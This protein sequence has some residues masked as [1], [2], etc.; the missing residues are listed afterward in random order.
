MKVLFAKVTLTR[1]NGSLHI[2]IVTSLWNMVNVIYVTSFT[3][4]GPFNIFCLKFLYTSFVLPL[5][6][7]SKIQK[8]K[9]TGFKVDKS[10]KHWLSQTISLKYFSRFYNVWLKI[11]FVCAKNC[12]KFRLFCEF[13]S[14]I[15]MMQNGIP[16]AMKNSNETCKYKCGWLIFS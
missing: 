13:Y 4:C 8:W 5:E 11:F 12:I 6:K 10:S 16:I 1:E 9:D 3:R 15:G 7:E 14:F 2:W